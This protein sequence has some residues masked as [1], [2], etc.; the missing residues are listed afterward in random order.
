MTK[1]RMV[2][3]GAGPGGMAAALAASRVG[4]EV[5][6]LELLPEGDRRSAAQRHRRP[7]R[8]DQGSRCHRGQLNLRPEEESV[9]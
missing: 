4:V 8:R 3:V 2:A 5:E 9:D 7:T 1:G 6:I